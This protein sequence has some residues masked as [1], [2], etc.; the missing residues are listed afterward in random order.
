MMHLLNIYPFLYLSLSLSLSLCLSLSRS[1]CLSVSLVCLPQ[2][3][4]QCTAQ[5]FTRW[6]VMIRQLL[7]AV[8][9]LKRCTAVS[10]WSTM[11]K[12][13]Q[14]GFGTVNCFLKQIATNSAIAFC[15]YPHPNRQPVQSLFIY[16]FF[17][18]F[19]QGGA[20]VVV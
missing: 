20:V 9:L 17:F 6:S 13:P 16:S 18:L 1:L 10:S 19:G 12:C 14:R 2:S 8:T 5:L 4:G 7:E 3:S 11:L 15:L